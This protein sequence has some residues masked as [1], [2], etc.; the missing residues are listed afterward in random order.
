MI[1]FFF[2]PLESA[3]SLLPGNKATSVPD[4]LLSDL[5]CKT[6]AFQVTTPVLG[7]LCG[8]FFGSHAKKKLVNER[9]NEDFFKISLISSC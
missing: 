3:N 4:T 9:Q 1:L 7:K 5:K 2:S 6:Q 8:P